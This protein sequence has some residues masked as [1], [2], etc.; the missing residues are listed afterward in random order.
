MLMMLNGTVPSLPTSDNGL[1]LVI[2][3]IRPTSFL[4]RIVDP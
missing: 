4:G 2:L 3:L 1:S